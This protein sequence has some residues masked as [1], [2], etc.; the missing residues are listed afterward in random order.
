MLTRRAIWFL[1]N[2]TTLNGGTA[3]ETVACIAPS[4]TSMCLNRAKANY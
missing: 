4:I 3:V 1:P 2:Y